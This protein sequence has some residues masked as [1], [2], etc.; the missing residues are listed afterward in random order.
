MTFFFRKVWQ[1]QFTEADLKT[2]LLRTF[3]SSDPEKIRELALP[4]GSLGRFRES[5]DV[6]ARKRNRAG[7]L[8]SPT[9]PEQYR[10]LRRT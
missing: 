10:K 5:A 3:T 1:V 9:H 7:R 8:L 4:R 2:P 6:G